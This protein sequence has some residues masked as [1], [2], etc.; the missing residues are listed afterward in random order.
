MS[1]VFTIILCTTIWDQTE[2]LLQ[3]DASQDLENQQ[4]FM[5]L[6]HRLMSMQFTFCFH[7]LHL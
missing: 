2:I 5:S 1:L 6:L 4:H 3:R 7:F